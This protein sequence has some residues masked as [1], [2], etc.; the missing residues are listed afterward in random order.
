MWWK[1]WKSFPKC[2][3]TFR[4]GLGIIPGMILLRSFSR[5]IRPS[6]P[7]LFLENMSIIE[8][9]KEH[10][11][12][13]VILMLPHLI[14]WWFHFFFS[15]L[16]LGNGVG[17]NHQPEHHWR[18][19]TYANGQFLQRCLARMGWNYGSEESLSF[20]QGNY[21]P[22]GVVLGWYICFKKNS[23]KIRLMI[24]TACAI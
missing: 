16:T 14:R 19:S 24:D 23:Q 21:R 3:E 8:A 15:P 2:L 13:K 18:F 11:Q 7:F 5:S 1:V 9:F 6:Y 20:F 17:W 12:K 10:L 22:V 4:F